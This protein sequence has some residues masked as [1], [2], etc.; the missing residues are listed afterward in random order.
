MFLTS[1]AH[2]IRKITL[3]I[4]EQSTT[5]DFYIT[6]GFLSTLCS[7][8]SPPP[9]PWSP[10]AWTRW[11]RCSR[12]PRCGQFAIADHERRERVAM[13]LIAVSFF[14]LAA[15]VTAEAITSLVR[16]EPADH[17]TVG[18]VLAAVSVVVMPVLS[19]AE[20]RTG[21]ELGPA[22]RSPILGRRCCT[23]L[24][25]VLLVGLVLNS[26]LVVRPTRSPR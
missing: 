2:S 9:L 4:L 22:P 23:Y 24:S 25:G 21:R 1:K 5:F 14:G 26:A 12:R 20:R 10:S 17:S 13:R 3:A 7:R 8:E 16:Q 15:F 18:I 19:W 11:S 6:G